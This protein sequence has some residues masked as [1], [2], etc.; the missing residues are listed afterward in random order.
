MVIKVGKDFEEDFDRELENCPFK[1]DGDRNSGDGNPR[2]LTLAGLCLWSPLDYARVR[3]ETAV[4]R[5][6]FGGI[7]TADG[8]EL[9]GNTNEEGL[10]VAR[11]AA[12]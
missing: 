10:L 9:E 4:I 12:G 7:A 1:S 2:M 3:R 6:C 5:L 11:V 8:E